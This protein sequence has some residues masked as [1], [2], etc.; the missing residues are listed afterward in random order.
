M[1]LA[2]EV[3]RNRLTIDGKVVSGRRR[4]EAAALAVLV[5]GHHVSATSACGAPELQAAL[6]AH[7]QVRPLNRKQLSRLWGAVGDMFEAA[8]KKRAFMTRLGHAARGLTVGP[9]WWT[10]QPGDR[11]R[12]L[13]LTHKSAV[14]FELPC[15][16]TDATHEQIA[17][18]CQHVVVYQ[19]LVIDGLH[20]QAIE[21]LE[22]DHAW[23]CASPEF[24]AFRHLSLAET[25]LQCSAFDAAVKAIAASKRLLDRCE[26][27][28]MYLGGALR[29]IQHRLA[30]GKAPT[31][32]YASISSELVP[33]LNQPPGI[34]FAEV[35]RF[36]RGLALNLAALCERRWLEEHA[37]RGAVPVAAGHL[38][39]ALRYWFAALFGF[40]TSNQYEYA[41]NMCSNIGY[42]LHRAFELGLDVRPQAALEWYAVAQVWQNRFDLADNNVW[43]YIFLGEFWLYQPKVRSAFAAMAPRV[44]WE[45]RR[46][47]T[48]GFY[49]HAFN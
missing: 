25:H 46:P 1:N 22:D 24:Q 40:I 4:W 43:E 6:H 27:A 47:D 48:L 3:A 42:L 33:L 18:L 2:I 16:A 30:Y 41:Q 37:K 20:A 38:E 39:A 19:G 32:N 45:G 9:W 13:D 10:L 21:A 36:T 7:G 34:R 8:G 14:R 28:V 5:E 11:H 17:A 29:L 31:K 23:R 49:E 12:V 15:L 26:V 44:V 35:D